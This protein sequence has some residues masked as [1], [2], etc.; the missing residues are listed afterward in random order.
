M[1][2]NKSLNHH[3]LHRV[4]SLR[5]HSR[6]IVNLCTIIHGIKWIFSSSFIAWRKSLRYHSWHGMNLCI[7]IHGINWICAHAME[8]VNLSALSVTA[9]NYSQHHHHGTEW[10]HHHSWHGVNLCTNIH[11]IQRISVHR[12]WHWGNL[13]AIS[14]GTESISA[15]SFFARLN[16]CTIING[17]EWIY[18]PSFME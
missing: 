6:H 9:R 5:Y 14:H 18:A 15:P 1:A 16:L 4:K 7:I 13:F 3:L 17:M 10:T 11:G 8:W 2:W 12:L